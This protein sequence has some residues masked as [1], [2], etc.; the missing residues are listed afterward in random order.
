MKTTKINL[1]KQ[2]YYMAASKDGTCWWL[3]EPPKHEESTDFWSCDGNWGPVTEE[4][5]K[6]IIGHKLTFEESP[7]KVTTTI[8]Y[9]K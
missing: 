3:D 4:T 6:F 9:N 1:E 2:E 8:I 5:C 7:I